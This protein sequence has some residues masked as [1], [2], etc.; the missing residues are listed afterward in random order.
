VARLEK[1]ELS[2]TIAIL[3]DRNPSDAYGRATIAGVAARLL[4]Q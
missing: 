4:D 3:T 2:L 1:G